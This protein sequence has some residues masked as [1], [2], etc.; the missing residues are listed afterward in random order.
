MKHKA[1]IDNYKNNFEQL[2]EEIG[3]L[4]YDTLSN[5]LELL[6]TKIKKDGQKDEGRG[7]QKLANLLYQ[8]S[9]LLEDSAKTMSKTWDLCEPYMYPIDIQQKIK[10]EFPK[11]EEQII[12]YKLLSDFYKN[13]D[14]DSNF[15][16]ARCILFDTKGQLEQVKININLAI[17]DPRDIFVQA[18]YD[19]QMNWL[20]DYNKP[21]GDEINL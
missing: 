1:W 3:N 18:E 12:I 6:A 19:E 21:F 20:R 11:K 14:T 2:A 17:T 16:L 7:R 8:T 4:R 9:N 15:R 13:W 10:S 5:F